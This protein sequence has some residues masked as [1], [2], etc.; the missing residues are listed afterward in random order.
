[1]LCV[2]VVLTGMVLVRVWGYQCYGRICGW[3][4]VCSF[5][6]IYIP[7]VYSAT[8]LIR[9]ILALSAC[10]VSDVLSAKFAYRVTSDET[11]SDEGDFAFLQPDGYS[12]DQTRGVMKVA[13]YACPPPNCLNT[14]LFISLLLYRGRALF[15]YI[16]FLKK[17]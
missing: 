5:F 14:T 6:Q 4:L 12:R 1:V 17:T 9:S 11:S 3:V 15:H 7:F 13:S 8:R 16:Y 10:I 2:S